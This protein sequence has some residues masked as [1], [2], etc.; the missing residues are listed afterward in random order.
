MLAIKTTQPCLDL[1]V[2]RKGFGNTQRSKTRQVGCLELKEA[3]RALDGSP[4]QFDM[5]V[6]DRQDLY[7]A[8]WQ[9]KS[10]SNVERG[11]SLGS[12]PEGL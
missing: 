9:N 11:P 10:R 1:Q 3:S 4:K 12:R 2:V 8:F 7:V 6:H 5:A